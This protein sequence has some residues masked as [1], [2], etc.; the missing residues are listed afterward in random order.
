MSKLHPG[1][2]PS[3]AC[4]FSVHREIV[5]VEPR[6]GGRSQTC[7]LIPSMQRGHE[8]PWVK[9]NLCLKNGAAHLHRGK[10]LVQ[11]REQTDQN[12]KKQERQSFLRPV[13]GG[14]RAWP[15]AD[16][17][18]A[19]SAVYKQRVYGYPAC[20]SQQQLHGCAAHRT[21]LCWAC[22]YDVA[23]QLHGSYMAAT[24]SDATCT[25]D[26]SAFEV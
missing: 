3:A 23:R 19:D 1:H 15:L 12:H 25:T 18:Q 24:S 11:L 14:T 16:L 21:G 10:S 4:S 22:K 20:T 13:I 9:K 17:T 7:T 26:S 2:G 8:P 5:C 6:A